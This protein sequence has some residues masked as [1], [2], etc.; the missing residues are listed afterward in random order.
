[1]AHSVS[2]LQYSPNV[3]GPLSSQSAAPTFARIFQVNDV[4][5]YLFSPRRQTLAF[6]G[7]LVSIC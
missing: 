1:M 4:V 6:K 7:F 3:P 5:D 2:V